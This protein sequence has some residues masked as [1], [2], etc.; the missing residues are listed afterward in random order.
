M[1][2]EELKYRQ[3]WALHQKIDHAVGTIDSFISKTGGG[4]GAYAAEF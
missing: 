3:S 2:Y 4:G 1:T